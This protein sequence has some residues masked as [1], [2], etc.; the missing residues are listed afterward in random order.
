M[1]EME[2]EE[3]RQKREIMVE[4]RDVPK[5]VKSFANVGFPGCK[6]CSVIQELL[7]VLPGI[8]A[9]VLPELIFVGTFVGLQE[10]LFIFVG[11]FNVTTL[12][13]CVYTCIADLDII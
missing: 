2:V 11:I 9:W 3:Y 7:P 10:L 13:N 6:C 12:F 4:G 8:S 5:P 1:S